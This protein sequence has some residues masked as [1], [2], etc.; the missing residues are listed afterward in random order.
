VINIRVGLDV[1]ASIMH[2][3]FHPVGLYGTY[4]VS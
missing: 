2:R 4:G 3:Q 1:E